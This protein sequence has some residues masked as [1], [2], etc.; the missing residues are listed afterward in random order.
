MKRHRTDIAAAATAPSGT[1]H[2][3]PPAEPL[4]VPGAGQPAAAPQAQDAL[5]ADLLAALNGARRIQGVLT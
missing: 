1:S 2:E 3:S 4:E 5:L